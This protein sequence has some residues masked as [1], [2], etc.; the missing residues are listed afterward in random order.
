MVKPMTGRRLGPWALGQYGLS[1]GPAPACGAQRLIRNYA[2][3]LEYGLLGTREAPRHIALRTTLMLA[4]GGLGQIQG[5]K[6]VFETLLLDAPAFVQIRLDGG[7]TF[8]R[9]PE[10]RQAA[11]TL[12]RIAAGL[13]DPS[14]ADALR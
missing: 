5:A 2:K 11:T 10:H 8:L 3:A 7:N 13:E 4:H 12:W 9:N 6:V 1:P 14:A